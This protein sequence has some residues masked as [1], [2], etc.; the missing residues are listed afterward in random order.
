[1]K[2][3]LALQLEPSTFCTLKC[4]TCPRTAFADTWKNIHFPLEKIKR[5]LPLALR[6]EIVQLQGWGEPLCHPEL[7]GMIRELTKAGARCSVT[8]NGCLLDEKRGQSLL[9]AGLEHLT[10]SISGATPETHA[11]LRPHS[12]LHALMEKVRLFRLRADRL[13]KKPKISLS[14]LQQDSNIHELPLAV[15]LA[16]RYGLDDCLAINASYLP[17]PDHKKQHVVSGFR[18]RWAAMRALWVS[19]RKGQPY[20]PARMQPKEQAVCA[21]DPLQCLMVGADGTVSPCIFLYLPLISHNAF[22]PPMAVMG[23]LFDDDFETIWQG[24]KYRNFCR[25]FEVRKE[26]YEE[27]YAGIGNCSEGRRRLMEAP[28]IERIFYG[29]H[30][31]PLPCQGCAQVKG[32]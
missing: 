16:S 27:L 24:K 23:N 12:D 6:A 9:E 30:P 19:I 29:N 10:I 32:L 14:F 15:G 2:K 18:S 31:V 20:I 21:N 7:E 26:F 28:G 1:M 22:H 5:I 4:P 8:S 25:A 17:T 13:G 11:A 3:I